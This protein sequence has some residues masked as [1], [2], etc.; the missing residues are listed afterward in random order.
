[1]IATWKIF[2]AAA[3]AACMAIPAQ[4]SMNISS[5]PTKNVVCSGGVCSPTAKGAILNVVDLE[6]LLA[7]QDVAVDT[8]A[9]A[10]TL[11][12]T[13][14][15]SWAS[16]HRLNLNADFN[17]SIKSVIAVEGTAVLDINYNNGGTTGQLLFFPGGRIDF[18]DNASSLIVNQETYFLV[19]DL[20]SLA[21]AVAASP[22]GFFAFAKDYDAG[23]D[24]TY[25]DAVSTV[26]LGGTLEGLGH[27]VSNLS[28]QGGHV[29]VMGMFETTSSTAIIRDL[30]LANVNIQAQGG[31]VGAFAGQGSGNFVGLSSSGTVAGG[32]DSGGLIG[33]ITGGTIMNSQSSATVTGN[34]DAGGLAALASSA[35]TIGYSSS[36]G[37]VAGG[38]HSETG[39]LIGDLQGQIIQSY[40]TA[41]V[42]SRGS[43]EVGGLV[44]GS[45]GT[46]A[47]SYSIGQVTAGHYS[48][49][50]GMLGATGGSVSRSYSTTAVVYRSRGARQKARVGGF[51]GR[52]LGGPLASDY[53]D[54]DTSLQSEPCANP[55]HAVTGLSDA[56][57][58]SGLPSGFDPTI[59]AQSPSINAGYPYLIANPPQ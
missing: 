37:H 34:Q 43:D 47:D 49:L 11:E 18:W 56:A 10:V 31:M 30:S 7:T 22:S 6:N 55:C 12:V 20:A 16:N 41:I 29:T 59:W 13:A 2:P 42:D 36:D 25:Q 27:T 39:G 40:S 54:I 52:Y 46:V 44:G 48:T 5:A 26:G 33:W 45:T 38:Q 19:S 14:P 23:P 21:N 9:G 1:M 4:A 50:G 28:I 24:G 57:L 17:V 35:V 15:L 58:K 32:T 53:W 8:G 3:L 51:A